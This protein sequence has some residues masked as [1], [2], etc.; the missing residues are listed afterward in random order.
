MLG[1]SCVTIVP[2]YLRNASS[3]KLRATENWC[4]NHIGPDSPYTWFIVEAMN[5]GWM[6]T[7][8][9]PDNMVKHREFTR[10]GVLYSIVFYK[11]ED[12]TAFRLAHI[13]PPTDF[14]W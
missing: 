8:G 3:L 13:L 7:S 12:A 14:R 6:N 4:L 11:D 1:T 10:A 2:L 9:D 5:A